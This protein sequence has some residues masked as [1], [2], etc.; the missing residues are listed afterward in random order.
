MHSFILYNLKQALF[1]YHPRLSAQE[2][3]FLNQ[4]IEYNIKKSG[5]KL[6]WET[7]RYIKTCDNLARCFCNEDVFTVLKIKAV[8]YPYY[9]DRF[10]KLS[11]VYQIFWCPTCRKIH[12]KKIYD[13]IDD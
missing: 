8:T 13:Q 2:Y 3:G 4:A 9:S 11:D 10:N 1:H 12:T 7:S 6:T 5:Y